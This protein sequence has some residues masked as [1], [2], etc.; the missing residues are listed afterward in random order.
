MPSCGSIRSRYLGSRTPGWARGVRL[1]EPAAGNLHG[2]VC[3]G[4]APGRATV[5]LNG[6]EAGNGGYSQRKPTA[7]LASSTRRGSQPE[8]VSEKD[9]KNV[10]QGPTG[11]V[12]NELWVRRTSV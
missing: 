9:P 3:E 2:G 4:G 12:F 8:V 11:F 1:D 7:H 6:H 5:D 10:Q